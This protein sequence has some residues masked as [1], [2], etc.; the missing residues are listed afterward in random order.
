MSSNV[1]PLS[2]FKTPFVT[3]SRWS[4]INYTEGHLHEGANATRA[5]GN[6]FAEATAYEMFNKEYEPYPAWGPPNEVPISKKDIEAIFID[7]M[8]IF[9]FQED[10][11]KNSF[12]LMMRLLDSRA[13]RMSPSHA[14]KLIHADY[15]SGINANFRKWYFGAML[16]VDDDIGFASSKSCNTTLEEREAYW[17]SNMTNIGVHEC[18]NHI[19]LYI[20]CWGE[21]AN[22][23]FMPECLCFIF[24][25]CC[26]SYYFIKEEGI[27]KP[28]SNSFLDHTI[29]PLYEF[30]YNQCYITVNGIPQRNNK[31]HKDII[32]YDDMNQ[33]FWY[34]KGL[35][36]ICL[37]ENN[38]KLMS[39]PPRERYSKLNKVV[40][41]KAFRKTFY[42]KRSWLHV[43]SN[44]NRIWIIHIS[45][46]WYYTSFN[47]PS[48]Y[49]KNYRQA[50]NNKPTTKAILSIMSLGGA[51]AAALTLFS[52]ICELIFVPR[53]WPGAKPVLKRIVFLSTMLTANSLPTWYLLSESD[54]RQTATELTIATIEFV[55]SII[56]VVYLVITPSGQL[57]NSNIVDHR[58][59]TFSHKS[60]VSN[61]YKLNGSSRLTSVGMWCGV[62]FSKFVESYFF[63]TLSLRDPIRELGMIKI[64]KCTGDYLFGAILC[65]Y[66]AWILLFLILITDLVLFFLDTYLWYIVWNTVFSV[67]RSF[68]IGVSIWTPW[69]NIFS[70]LPKR[71]FSKIICGN[72]KSIRAKV[73]VSQIWNSIVIA[74]YREHLL[75]LEHVQNLIY[76][77]IRIEGSEDKAFLKEPNF[78]VSHEDQSLSF[79]LFTQPSE[80]QRRITFFAQSLATPMPS[81]TS[82]SSTPTFSVLIPHYGE[83]IILALKEIIRE[84][85]KYSN[86]TLLEYLKLLHPLEWSC[87][88][89]D[90][91]L[92]AE[93]F[94]TDTSSTGNSMVDNKQDL[95]YYCVG[96]K[97]A[98]PEYITRT[99]IWASLRAQTLYRTVAGF[100]NYSRAIK[101]LYDVENPQYEDEDD[102]Y[103]RLE[104]AAVMALRKFRIVISM[105]NM[106]HF[107]SNENENKEFLLRAY[108]ELQ[109]CYLDHDIDP[110]SSE[111]VYYSSLIDGTCLLSETG[112]RDPK[113]KIRLP[114]NPILGDGKSDNQN[115]AIIYTR[116]EYLQ[117][118]DAN[119]DNYL[120]ECLKIRSVL[121]EFEEVQLPLDPIGPDNSG[122]DYSHPVA[123]VGTRE[124]IFSENVGI[125][126]DVAA[127]KEQTFGTLFARTLAH[128]GGKLHYGHPD[129]LNV[130]FMTTRGG[131][132][133]AQKG[134]HLNEDIYAGINAIT[135]GG[136]IKHCEY[137]QCGKGR[138]L[139]FGSILN[140]C[141]KIGAG[142]GEQML[143]REYFYL[144]S[145]LPLDRFLSFYYAHPG[146]HIN[147]LFIILSISML[148]LVGVNLSALVSESV[149]CEY[150]R[151]RPITDPRKPP[152]C[153]NLIPIVQWLERSIYSILIVF[154]IAFIPLAVQELTER[155]FYKAIS[156][157]GKQF[158]SLS[159]TFEVFVCRIYAQS[160]AG[161]IASGGAKY[162]ATGRGFAT[163]RVPF[164]ILY[165]RYATESL[166]FGVFCGVL[167][168]FCSLVMWKLPLIYFWSTA[169]GLLLSPFIFNPNQYSPNQFLKDYK[170]F[171]F[172]I[173]SGNS[174]ARLNSWS[175]FSKMRRARQVGV[176]RRTANIDLDMAH[177][178]RVSR[179][180]AFITDAALQ[181]SIILGVGCAYLFANSQNEIRGAMP[182]N[183]VLR[184]LI[185]AYGPIAVNVIILLVF[186]II[187]MITGPII[188]LIFPWYPSI[189]AFFCRILG[190]LSHVIGFHLLCYLQNYD[191]STT[192]LGFL[193]ACCLVNL[194]FI[195]LRVLLSKEFSHDCSNRAWWSGK[196]LTSGLGC[197]IITQIPREFL[198]KVMEM[199]EFSLDFTLGNALFF[200]QV[201]I[202]LIPYVDTWHSLMLF[203]LHPNQQLRPP[204]IA[205]RERRK[206]FW[207]FVLCSTLFLF[208]LLLSTS[209][210]TFPLVLDKAL[211]FSFDEYAPPFLMDLM[212]PYSA[213]LARKGLHANL[214][215]TYY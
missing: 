72:L 197:H 90:T 71:I 73:A 33:L 128:V 37:S 113:Y 95:P 75:S 161:D 196:W 32:G 165:S 190:L 179:M 184:I 74:M 64:S 211:D 144:S 173:F 49:A 143:S 170:H 201:P 88:V 63:L 127:G 51:I 59:E 114:G 103:I 119:Q 182:S 70:A 41:K 92:L 158:A 19:A 208:M 204:I 98:T 17:V 15:V 192:I 14:L 36:R 82:S 156:R 176:K 4:D 124:Y 40:W 44:F 129:F 66:Q 29:K 183:S 83:K 18:T 86:I 209:I 159:P 199:S 102:E 106:K 38:T 62:F 200:I 177:N 122:T 160:L 69:R 120:E 116:G 162:I 54:Q 31:D 30:Y 157:L 191:F 151:F 110:Q 121:N 16:D 107:D 146:F 187:S 8:E 138:D 145:E 91:K 140:F 67:C 80:A 185:V 174:K 125:L 203:W 118:I 20:M 11:V 135:R 22:I 137:M 132:S 131:C 134:L 164:S 12:D 206:V 101:L 180:L 112:D 93:E 3:S 105:Q 123:I 195:F 65:Q 27:S 9:G 76:R 115:M 84:E 48:L 68:Y 5:P 34:R 99:R 172:W 205:K 25:C 77:E 167:V 21:A 168:L 152:G 58:R 96:Y 147:N 26:D 155:G 100:M 85:E 169:A 193:L 1:V 24:K 55:F 47:A 28:L 111:L 81:V 133:K 45:M 130:I 202:I 198:C 207:N 139:G 23:R 56:T 94:A 57:F 214:V 42:E 210:V 213:K 181:S 89:K 215:K 35:E 186:Q 78:F 178:V 104:K 141:T 171:L 163:V 43:I 150:D 2:G 188:S 117:L 108:P 39:F 46:F 175:Q 6:K 79:G 136:R 166:Y 53:T 148:L 189:I 142:M 60:F 126:G 153:Y 194:L 212:Q 154:S 97:V 13:S 149:I 52:V 7:L 10:N 50:F 87:F 109:I 61:F